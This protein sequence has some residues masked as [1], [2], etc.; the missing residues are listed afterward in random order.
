MNKNINLRSHL[1]FNQ[2]FL[3]LQGTK[4]KSL[5]ASKKNI[6]YYQQNPKESQYRNHEV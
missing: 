5:K 1:Q 3:T 4:E 6:K 2:R